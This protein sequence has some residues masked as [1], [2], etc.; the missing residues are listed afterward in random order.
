MT[1]T[2]FLNKC[3]FLTDTNKNMWTVLGFN[4]WNNLIALWPLISYKNK[5]YRRR[6]SWEFIGGK[7]KIMRTI[8]LDITHRNPLDTLIDHK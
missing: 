8:I 7:K 4:Q 3:M 1:I 5:S 6:L 2:R